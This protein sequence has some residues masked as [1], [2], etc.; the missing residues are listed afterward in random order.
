[1]FELKQKVSDAPEPPDGKRLA[2]AL[3]TQ[4]ASD[5]AELGPPLFAHA[6][7]RLVEI[8]GVAPADRVLDV[9]TG[10]GAVLFPAAERIG[11]TGQV[12]GIDLA[13]GMV[14][15]T[16]GAI[17]KCGLS[18]TAVRQMD[19]EALGFAPASFDRLLCSFAVFFFP[20]LSRA[21]S[22]MLRVLRPGGR[23]GFAFSRGTDAG[24]HWYEA[25]L[26]ELGAFDALPAQ[27]GRM[28]IRREGELTAALA[29]IGFQGA[30]EFVEEVELYFPDENAWWQSLST[31]G[32]RRPLD[33]LRSKAP[34][35]LAS[36]KGES[37]ER[38]RALKGPRG[39]PERHTFVYVTGCRSTT[40][41][42]PG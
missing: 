21:L 4:V 16:A 40:D 14:A 26:R 12:I 28:G 31:H 19:A 32:T 36:F 20:D 17:E 8:A 39:I 27:P 10:R 15:Q 9:A 30:Q 33:H 24:W 42:N 6:G 11:P 25:R 23:I 38:V 34:E 37:L 22:E 41:R 7:R 13:E 3:Y 2:A 18:N 35:M 1:M 5:Y 29:A